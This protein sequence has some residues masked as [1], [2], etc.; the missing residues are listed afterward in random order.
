MD[1]ELLTGYALMNFC[2]TFDTVDHGLLKG[3]GMVDKKP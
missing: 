2:E 3:C 1:D